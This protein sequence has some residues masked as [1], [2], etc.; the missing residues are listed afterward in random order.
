MTSYF[1]D[2]LLEGFPLAESVGFIEQDG[3]YEGGSE[4]CYSVFEID[5]TYYKVEYSYYSHYGFDTNHA[6]VSIVSPKEK[7]II[8]YE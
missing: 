6:Q 1:T 3:G 4:Y 8:V 7:T 2:G 5:D